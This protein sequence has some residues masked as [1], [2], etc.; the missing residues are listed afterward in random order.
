MEAF[1]SVNSEYDDFAVEVSTDGGLSFQWVFNVT[2]TG[3]PILYEADLPAVTSG[4]II[5]RV[6]DEDRTIGNGATDSLFVDFLAIETVNPQAPLAEVTVAASDPSALEG[7]AADP[8]AFTVSRSDP[9]GSLT[10]FYTVEGSATPDADYQSL[11]GS[12]VIANGTLDAVVTVSSID[13][14]LVEGDESVELVLSIGADYR[15]GMPSS[16]TVVIADDDVSGSEFRAVTES[17]VYGRVV[18]GDHTST[19][20]ADGSFEVIDEELYAGQKRSRL[21]H[22]W[23]FITTGSNL[24]F[25]LVGDRQGPVNEGVSFGYSTDGSSWSPMSVSL[26]GTAQTFVLPSTVTGTIY[27]RVIDDD[28]NRNEGTI[29]TIRIDEMFLQS[30]G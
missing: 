11:S 9:V 5:V 24:S 23:T 4:E 16:A 28:R 29:D 17:T 19:H 25:H 20:F 7:D 18:S 12:V 10:V 2:A 30:S 22:Q 8:G 26:N 14:S 27:V 15:L 6:V 1:H 21:E 3:S 13:D